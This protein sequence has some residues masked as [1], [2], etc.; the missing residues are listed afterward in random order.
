M[1]KERLLKLANH[2]LHGKLGHKNFDFRHYNIGH[3]EESLCGTNGCGIGEC[4]VIF[5][6]WEFR[7]LYNSVYPLLKDRKGIES[8][9]LCSMK[10]FDLTD[11]ETEILFIPAMDSEKGSEFRYDGGD[12][13]SEEEVIEE[14]FIIIGDQVLHG[15]PYSATKEQV[16]NQIIEFVRLKEKIS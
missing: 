9:H 4:P 10:F 16:A 7:P 11:K 2:L 1:N 3:S 14:V 13:L 8:T 15:L 12:E 5:D 6:E